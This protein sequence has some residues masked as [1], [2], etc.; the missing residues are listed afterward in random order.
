M[1]NEPFVIDN[2]VKAEWAIENI[3]EARKERDRLVKLCE[4]QIAFY[5]DK[6]ENT[7]KRCEQ[8]EQPLIGMLQGYFH[9]VKK[10][11]TKTSERYDLVRGRLV[12]KFES[13]KIVKDDKK[14]IE[15]LQ[16]TE[17]IEQVP[18]LKW[19]ELKANLV[20]NGDIV[21]TQDGEIL[22]GLSTEVVPASFSVEVY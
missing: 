17:Y 18:K 22:D 14:L 16:G 21:T 15:A 8:D 6:I 11:K 20:I 12:K 2:D 4:D 9:S 19:A 7:I 10:R 13:T 5:T 1:E 3:I